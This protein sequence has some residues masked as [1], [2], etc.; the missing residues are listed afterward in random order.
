[1]LLW[2]RLA[3]QDFWSFFDETF[4][5]GPDLLLETARHNEGYRMRTAKEIG[6]QQ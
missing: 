6:S 5:P 4:R 2:Q 3:V 1:M